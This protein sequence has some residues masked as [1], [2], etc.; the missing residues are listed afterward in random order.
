MDSLPDSRNEH[1]EIDQIN[2]LIAAAGIDG[3]REILHA[4]W[5]TAEELLEGASTHVGDG[6]LRP[7]AQ[8]AHAI[9]GAA[10]NIGAARLADTAGKLET[11]CRDGDQDRALL[12]TRELR[13]DFEAARGWLQEHL[14]QAS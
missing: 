13:A 5:R 7:A 4:F 11:A 14:R 8:T 9:K 3:A 6:A 12:L 10:A 2:G 1:L